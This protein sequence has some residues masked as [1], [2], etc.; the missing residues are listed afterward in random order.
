[1]LAATVFFMTWKMPLMTRVETVTSRPAFHT[2][3]KAVRGRPERWNTLTSAMT[4]SSIAV[5]SI[6][7]C[8]WTSASCVP[9][10]TFIALV[11]SR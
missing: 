10:L 6:K 7:V 5:P 11:N 4:M 2:Q 8:V 1:M 3:K 9:P